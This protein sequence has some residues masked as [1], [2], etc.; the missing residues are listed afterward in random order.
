MLA[1]F[2]PLRRSKKKK[3]RDLEPVYKVVELE[4]AMLIIHFATNRADRLEAG[5]NQ[6]QGVITPVHHVCISG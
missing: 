2:L 1:P 5:V 4:A 6:F 3:F